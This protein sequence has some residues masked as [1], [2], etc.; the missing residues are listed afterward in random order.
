[1]IFRLIFMIAIGWLV[2]RLFRRFTGAGRRSGGTANPFRRS[3]RKSRF[4]GK[5]VDADFEELDDR[6]GSA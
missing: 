5:A 2:Y 1:M 3:S 6:K 4:D